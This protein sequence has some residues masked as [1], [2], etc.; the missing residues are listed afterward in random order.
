[1]RKGKRSRKPDPA[2]GCNGKT[3]YPTRQAAFNALRTIAKR[4]GARISAYQIYRCTFCWTID[5][6]GARKRPF[7]FGHRPGSG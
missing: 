7:H 5:D 2:R 1:M 4:T 6:A 3:P